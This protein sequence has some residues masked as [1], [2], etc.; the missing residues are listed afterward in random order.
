MR[1][2]VL[3]VWFDRGYGFVTAEDRETFFLHVN[4]LE[5]PSIAP[6]KGDV[7]EFE[8]GD[9]YKPGKLP[10]AMKAKIVPPVLTVTK[11][12]QR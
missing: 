6:M 9:P 10:Q 4:N 8:A 5:N 7:I 2:G 3:T 11:A 1:R 12:V